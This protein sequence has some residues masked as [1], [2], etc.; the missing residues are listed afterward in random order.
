MCNSAMSVRARGEGLIA[1]ELDSGWH[2]AWRV[3]GF[4][5]VAYRDRSGWH[6]WVPSI[7]AHGGVASLAAAVKAITY[8][9]VRRQTERTHD[10][11]RA[12]PAGPRDGL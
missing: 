11:E 10:E 12:A 6:F 2:S 7:S 4:D 3:P 8:F 1:A 5:G 9:N